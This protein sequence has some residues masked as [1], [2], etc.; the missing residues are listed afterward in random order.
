[1]FLLSYSSC[2]ALPI[3]PLPRLTQLFHLEMLCEYPP[4]SHSPLEEE[5]G[6]SAQVWS[7]GLLGLEKSQ[8]YPLLGAWCSVKV[9]CT[10]K[11]LTGTQQR[12]IQMGT[13]I[14]TPE[15]RLT[16]CSG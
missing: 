14:S 16:D 15:R 3:Q 11:G 1:M 13:V 7:A 10:V 12:H 8:E 9:S 2:L 6:D 4:Q 5:V